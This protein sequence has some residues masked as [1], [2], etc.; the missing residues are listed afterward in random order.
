[1]TQ[2]TSSGKTLTS[3]YAGLPGS[4]GRQLLPPGKSFGF[5]FGEPGCGKS[6]LMESHDG[7]FIFNLDQTSTSNP[8]PA[9]VTWPTVDSDGVPID[10]SGIKYAVTWPEVNKVID[11]LVEMAENKQ[12]RPETIVFD[13]L[14]SMIALLKEWAPEGL[15]FATTTGKDFRELDGHMAWD[16]VYDTILRMSRRLR[17]AGYGVWLVGHT[18]KEKQYDKNG[19]VVG[20]KTVPTFTQAIWK[21]LFPQFEISATI[22]KKKVHLKTPKTEVIQLSGGKTRTRE[23]TETKQTTQYTFG[24]NVE[25]LKDFYK[26]RAYPEVILPPIGAWAVFCTA[27]QSELESNLNAMQEINNDN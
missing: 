6:H 26:G 15:P 11:I 19:N 17:Q 10:A 21:R 5:I 12:P 8:T 16:F 3:K 9:A 24:F 7:A 27:Y 2:G 13:S 18:V 4:T 22:T 1:M 20:T 25:D 23:T 14:T